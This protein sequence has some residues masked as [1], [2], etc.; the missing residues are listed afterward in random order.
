MNTSFDLFQI[1]LN[2]QG[3]EIVIPLGSVEEEIHHPLVETTQ[4]VHVYCNNL[5]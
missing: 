3:E 4:H 5:G 2:V 1:K